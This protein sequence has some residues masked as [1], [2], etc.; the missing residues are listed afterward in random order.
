ME[1]IPCGLRSLTGESEATPWGIHST[2]LRYGRY[3]SVIGDG[4]HG[5]AVHAGR[6]S[7]GPYRVRKTEVTAVLIWRTVEAPHA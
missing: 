1:R 5:D 2:S 4:C 3:D 7:Y 6:A